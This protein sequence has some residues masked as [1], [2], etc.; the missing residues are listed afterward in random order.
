MPAILALG[1]LIEVFFINR[2]IRDLDFY[3]IGE[4]WED[5][6]DIIDGVRKRF[7]MQVTQVLTNNT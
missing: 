7:P 6:G 1:D 5:I 4:M 2:K 3:V